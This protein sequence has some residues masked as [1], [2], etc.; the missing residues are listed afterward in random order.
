MRT[1]KYLIDANGNWSYV[2]L[3]DDFVA[4]SWYTVSNTKPTTITTHQVNV[5]RDKLMTS[6]PLMT[7]Y[8]AVDYD[9][10]S[11]E[12]LDVAY[13]ALRAQDRL[14]AAN[15]PHTHTWTMHDNTTVDLTADDMDMI[16]L[17]AASRGSNYHDAAKRVKAAILSNQP[18]PLD[19]MALLGL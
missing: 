5:R 6:S 10:L 9:A 18:P 13:R 2:K 15:A 12:K 4:P 8:G 1:F 16:T 17:S 14:D 7:P 3:P 11:R 19:D